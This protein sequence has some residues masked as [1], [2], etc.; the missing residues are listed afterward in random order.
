VDGKLYFDISYNYSGAA[1]YSRDLELWRSD[2]TAGGTGSV[3][4]LVAGSGEYSFLNDY[5][6]VGNT[7]Y[8][9]YCDTTPTILIVTFSINRTWA[10]W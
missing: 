6:F 5:A 8:F 10:L 3:G 1:G 2:G 9:S 7:L 4:K